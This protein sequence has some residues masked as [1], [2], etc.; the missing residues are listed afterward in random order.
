MIKIN[1]DKI[2]GNVIFVVEGKVTE[3]KLLE[4]IFINLLK[5]DEVYFASDD[6][7]IKKFKH[8]SLKSN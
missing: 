2:I 6:N 1:K 8:H 7:S 5:Y 3:S 4:E